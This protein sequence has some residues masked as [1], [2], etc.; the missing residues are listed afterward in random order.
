MKNNEFKTSG[1]LA[2]Q[3]NCVKDIP[4]ER[5][6]ASIKYFKPTPDLEYHKRFLNNST[7]L[8]KMISFND[9]KWDFSPYLDRKAS[10]YS[11]CY[12]GDLPIELAEKCK[13]FVVYKLHQKRQKVTTI[14]QRYITFRSVYNGITKNKE[15]NGPTNITTNGVI[16]EVQLTN[17]ITDITTNEICDEIR[18]RNITDGSALILY[19]G[20]FQVCDFLKNVCKIKLRIDLKKIKALIDKHAYARKR[21]SNKTP[22]VPE[23]YFNKIFN[24]AIKVM[25]DESVDI[26]MRMTAAA[27][28]LL[29]QTGLRPSDLLALTTDQLKSKTTNNKKLQVNYIHYKSFKPS[30]PGEPLQEFDIHCTKIAAEAFETMK[31]LRQNLA[32]AQNND[33]L[34]V[35]SFPHKC[36][37]P[38]NPDIFRKSYM[39]FMFNFL[40]DDCTRKWEG[41]SPTG[42]KEINVNT[43]LYIPT[44]PQYRVHY[45]TTLY[46]KNVNLVYIQKYMGHLSDNMIGYYARPKDNFQEDVEYTGKI[47]TEMVDED[48][49]PLGGRFIGEKLKEAIQKFVA[50]NK[51]DVRENVT[52]VINALGERLVIRGKRGGVCIRT[53]L[54]T[55]KEDVHTDKLM[56]AHSICP[57]LFHFYYMLDITYVDFQ[58]LQKSYLYLKQDGIKRAAEKELL[59]IK[60]LIKRRL[61]PELDE[62]EKEIDKKGRDAIITRHPEL[63]EVIEKRHDIRKE[64]LVW[65]T[66]E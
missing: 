64:T 20:V 10:S 45:C 60:D 18:R 3:Y 13:F 6:P 40:R 36:G 1:S 27:V 56:C 61:L 8:A 11:K 31:K 46:Q 19:Q 2:L 42:G 37:I 66:K 28:V 22:N 15:K 48:L 33:T 24:K 55:C 5:A 39:H 30:H 43:T 47:I 17:T 62:L 49:T 21:T 4:W 65:S 41:V 53:T 14:I 16:D 50:D 38:Y 7:D 34:F 32:T 51:F 29:S 59:K 44:A 52:D 26:D 58:T 23:E 54:E 9:D 12:F 57:N 35:L 25:R 63:V